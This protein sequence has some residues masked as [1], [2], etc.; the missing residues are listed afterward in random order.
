MRFINLI[1]IKT[2]INEKDAAK[3][4]EA[5]QLRVA[6]AFETSVSVLIIIKR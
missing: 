6:F 3:C 2:T 1:S 5:A 4:R